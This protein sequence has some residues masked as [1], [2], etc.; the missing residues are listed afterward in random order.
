MDHL[1][2]LTLCLS[3]FR[4]CSA[5]L[6]SPAG[7]MADFFA[8]VCF[9]HFSIWYPGSGVVLACIDS[10]SLPSFLLLLTNSFVIFL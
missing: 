1:C 4:V 7:K 2:N 6:W 9:C 5:A 10:S 8:L 3:C